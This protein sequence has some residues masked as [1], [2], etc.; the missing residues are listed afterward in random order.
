M[1]EREIEAPDSVLVGSGSKHK[2]KTIRLKEARGYHTTTC[3]VTAASI[4]LCQFGVESYQ[5]RYP[6][7]GYETKVTIGPRYCPATYTYEALLV[8]MSSCD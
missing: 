3:R 5:R 1:S 2:S 6:Y 8:R 7:A 4:E